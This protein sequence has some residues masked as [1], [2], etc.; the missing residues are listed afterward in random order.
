MRVFAEVIV[1]FSGLV[2]ANTNIG[3]VLTLIGPAE[4][5]CSLLV[6]VLVRVQ[7][8]RPQ[9]IPTVPSEPQQVAAGRRVHSLFTRCL[10]RAFCGLLVNLIRQT[11]ARRR[12]D[13]LAFW[14]RERCS[15][16]EHWK[17]NYAKLV[18]VIWVLMLVLKTKL[19]RWFIMWTTCW[20]NV[21]FTLFLES[22]R[23][24]REQTH[25]SQEAENNTKHPNKQVH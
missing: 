13:T 19:E 7:E 1:R 22:W 20:D 21:I 2:A 10:L 5:S 6:G 4:A 18:N 12:A 25:K 3:R 8:Q 23:R 24:W 14:G 15:H 16:E 9:I 11:F 17:S